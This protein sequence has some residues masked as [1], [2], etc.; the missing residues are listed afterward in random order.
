MKTMAIISVKANVKEVIAD[1]RD[2]DRTQ[3]PF[4]LAL[5]LTTTAKDGQAATWG[6]LQSNPA[7]NIR[8]AS[9]AKGGIRIEPATKQKLMSVVKDINWYM[10]LQETGGGKFPEFGAY[11]A[12]PLRGARPTPRSQIDPNNSPKRV[13]QRGGFIQRLNKGTLI[14]FLPLFKAGR[15]GRLA[16]GVGGIQKAASWTRQ[17]LPMYALVK[18]ATV[19]P[20]YGMRDVVE[21]IVDQRFAANFLWALDRALRTKK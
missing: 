10:E 11:I 14:M 5:G 21:R 1:L 20:E 9:W 19:R 4:A 3:I 7:F 2:V 8:R 15:R 17:V 18:R 12:V 16:K 6:H 13:M